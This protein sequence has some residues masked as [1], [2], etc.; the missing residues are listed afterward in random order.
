MSSF[1]SV[2]SDDS[3][4]DAGLLSA[5]LALRHSGRRNVLQSL[6]MCLITV[7][8]TVRPGPL[9]SALRDPRWRLARE[10]PFLPEIPPS[11]VAGFGH[12]C[13]FRCTTY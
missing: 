13:A 8:L 4:G 7:Q 11:G 3:D 9:R 10:G 12:A 1:S 6:R 2:A 5:L